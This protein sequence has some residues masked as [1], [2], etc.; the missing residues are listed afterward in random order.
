MENVASIYG[1]A[2]DIDCSSI[3]PFS[4]LGSDFFPF[5]GFFDG[6]F[7]KIKNLNIVNEGGPS[8]STIFHYFSFFF[9]FFFSFF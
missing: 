6:R 5:R 2:N 8:G 1:L 7:K 4:P 9:Y 3:S